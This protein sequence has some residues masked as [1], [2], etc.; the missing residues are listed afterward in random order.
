[1]DRIIAADAAA[2][3]AATTAAVSDSSE[4]SRRPRACAREGWLQAVRGRRDALGG[5]SGAGE[6]GG[7]GGSDGGG[8]G[9]GKGGEGG[10]CLRERTR[11]FSHKRAHAGRA[12]PIRAHA[13]TFFEVEALEEEVGAREQPPG[14]PPRHGGPSGGGEHVVR[15]ST[16]RSSRAACVSGAER[17]R[18]VRAHR[19]GNTPT[20]Q[21]GGVAV[22]GDG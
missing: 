15:R 11:T 9:R 8:A 1:M 7:S 20:V 19:P 18:R 16:W 6:G 13:R 14:G 12:G 3:A 2:T 10:V 17:G 5:E 21:M 4:G 22:G